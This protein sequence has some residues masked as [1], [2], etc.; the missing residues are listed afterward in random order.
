[1]VKGV[2]RQVIFVDSPDR[3]C[4]EKAIFL[5]RDGAQGLTEAEL[6]REAR[7]LAL[8]AVQ[9]RRSRAREC[10]RLLLAGLGGALL[11]GAA[12]LLAP[13]LKNL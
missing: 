13:L 3:D 7:G 6:L 11:V 12:W 10:G 4:F 9:P 2:T 8:R 5:L 1:M